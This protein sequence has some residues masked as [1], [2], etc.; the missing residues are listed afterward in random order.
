[1]SCKYIDT[2]SFESSCTLTNDDCNLSLDS[3][4]ASGETP[5]DWIM[6]LVLES[7]LGFSKDSSIALAEFRFMC[8][9]SFLTVVLG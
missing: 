8:L 7:L 6:S 1:M 5:I 3:S 2:F 4:A 9:M